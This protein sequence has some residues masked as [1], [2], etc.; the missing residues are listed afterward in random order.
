MFLRNTEE[1]PALNF[2]SPLE[3]VI[4]RVVS[5]NSVVEKR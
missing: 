4:T 2:L 5:K 3:T 1:L